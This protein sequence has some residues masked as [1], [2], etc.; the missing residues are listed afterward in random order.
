[1]FAAK[2]TTVSSEK[3][4]AVT[5][6]YLNWQEYK[7]SKNNYKKDITGPASTNITVVLICFWLFAKN[8]YSDLDLDVTS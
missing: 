6:T 3:R 4:N 7:M 1:M 8:P 2:G 5:E